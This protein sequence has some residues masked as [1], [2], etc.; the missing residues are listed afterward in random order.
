M[1]NRELI[2]RMV[3]TAELRDPEET[4]AHVQRVGAYSAEIYRTWATA[5]GLDPKTI[6]TGVDTIR[7]AAML[8]DVGKVG[9]PDAIIKK[10]GRLTDEERAVM[11][12]HTVFGARLFLN[13]S[14]E[15][16]RMSREIALNHHEKWAGGGYPGRIPD[17]MASQ[18]SMGTPKQGEEIPIAAR[19]V[20]LADVFDALTSRRSY[21]EPWPDDKVLAMIQEESGRQFDPDVVA[22]FLSIFEVIKAI[23]AKYREEGTPHA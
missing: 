11:Q 15:L 2:L 16:D 3:K 7:L 12:W 6:R 8:H 10:P 23:R 4:G 13:T 1:M 18:V 14:S 17:L 22:A 20:S 21:K 9:V 19:I 5:K